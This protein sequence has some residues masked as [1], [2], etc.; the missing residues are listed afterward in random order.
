MMTHEAGFG[1]FRKVNDGMIVWKGYPGRAENIG[2]SI[3]MKRDKFLEISF[4]IFFL[5]QLED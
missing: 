4:Y 3:D 5:I 1:I 2:I